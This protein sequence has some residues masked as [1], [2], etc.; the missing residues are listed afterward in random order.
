MPLA[1]TDNSVNPDFDVVLF[2]ADAQIK[3]VPVSGMEITFPVTI[4]VSWH[5]ALP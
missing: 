4:P 3:Y 2:F 5:T 1:M